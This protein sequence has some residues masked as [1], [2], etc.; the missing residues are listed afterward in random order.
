MIRAQVIA[1]LSTF[2]H[3][4]IAT[5]SS[6]DPD[7]YT[8]KVIFQ[9]DGNLSGQLPILADWVGNG[10]G[11]YYAPSIDD[12]VMVHFMEGSLSNGFIS[13]R[14]FNNVDRAINPGPPSGERWV[15]HQ[16][17]TFIKFKNDGTIEVNLLD[18]N[19]DPTNLNI[20]G[21]M[22]VDGN[23]TTTGDILDNSGTNSHTVKLMRTIYNTHTHPTPA[24][25]SSAP[26]QPM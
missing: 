5:I 4:R 12:Q 7:T 15:V 3:T 20:I 9:P 22:V 11:S 21:N 18:E 10:W 6:Y 26:N 16:T 13:G 19:G 25:T 23:I 8:A 14:I 24:G 2:T 17:G 1:V